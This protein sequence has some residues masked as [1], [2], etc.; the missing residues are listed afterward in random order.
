VDTETSAIHAFVGVPTN[1]SA[2]LSQYQKFVVGWY[3]KKPEIL[4]YI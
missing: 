1:K 2:G 4:P 3:I